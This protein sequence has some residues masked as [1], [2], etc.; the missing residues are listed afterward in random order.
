MGQEK[1]KKGKVTQS[2]LT[3]LNESKEQD[4]NIFWK[5]SCKLYCFSFQTNQ[6]KQ[7]GIGDLK[8]IQCKERNQIQM[9]LREKKTKNLRLNHI[10][11]PDV[12]L[13]LYPG[14]ENAWSWSAI[15]FSD[16]EKI[17][18]T[19]S[20]CLETKKISQEF[21]EK[22]KQACR[23]N[24]QSLEKVQE[25]KKKGKVTQSV[26]TKLNESKEQDENIFWKGSCK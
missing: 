9:L 21:V 16:G 17:N 3:K 7:R 2:V 24:S 25:K 18:R 22:Y 15:D 14:A 23:I 4:E 11:D 5:G 1:K 20:V 8:M 19:F 13:Q 12:K 6:W 26:L 10:I